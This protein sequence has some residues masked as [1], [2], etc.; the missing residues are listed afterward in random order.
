M[1]KQPV[2]TDDEE[3]KDLID[4]EIDSEVQPVEIESEV[5]INSE[6]EKHRQR[7]AELE[8]VPRNPQFQGDTE[9]T[10]RQESD[11]PQKRCKPSEGRSLGTYNGKTDVGTILVRLETC[12][13]YYFNWSESEKVFHLMN[14]LTDSAS[15]IVREVGSGG[16]LERILELL[17]VRFGNRARKAKFLADLHN[18]ECGPK[19]TLQEL[20][21]DLCE[22][23]ANAFSD[24][25]SEWFPEVYIFVD[26]LNDKELRRVILTQKPS[27]IK[28]AYNVAIELEAIEAYPTPVADPSQV[29]PRFWQLSW[30]LMDSLVF[31]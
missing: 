31:L 18:C 26:A 19:E 6:L 9:P 7:L 22:L 16:T 15:S 21:L 20:S 14:S 11:L 1:R 12:S 17:Q 30:E 24:D 29:K 2:T 3:Y 10:D 28:A 23:R 5:E 25:P 8:E 13:R 4:P 27:T